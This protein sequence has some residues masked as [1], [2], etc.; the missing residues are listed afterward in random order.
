MATKDLDDTA[1]LILDAASCRFL[2][3]GFKKTTMSEIAEDCNMSTGNLYRYFQS[4]L[5]IA[6]AFVAVL[7]RDHIAALRKIMETPDLTPAQK[8]RKFLLEKFKLVYE[9]YHDKPKA[10]ELSNSILQESPKIAQEWQDAEARVLADILRQGD[11]DGSF[12]VQDAPK[13]A[14]ILL[15]AAYRFTSPAV[16]LEGEYEYDEIA[17]EFDGVISLLLDALSRRAAPRRG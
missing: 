5:D 16:F 13:L 17:E 2:H 4:K 14:K 11:A 6:E 8:L 3:Y 10:F 9:R 7:R 15:D 1:K 12:A